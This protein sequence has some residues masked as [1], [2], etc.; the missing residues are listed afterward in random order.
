M[1]GQRSSLPPC[2]NVLKPTAT[3]TVHDQE[4]ASTCTAHAITACH[5]ILI[6]QRLRTRDIY[7][8]FLDDED[9]AKPSECISILARTGQ[10]AY[11]GTGKKRSRTEEESLSSERYILKCLPIERDIPSIK[12]KLCAGL[13]VV[14]GMHWHDSKNSKGNIVLADSSKRKTG[15]TKRRSLRN[16]KA[17]VEDSGKHCLLLIGY[18]DEEDA[19]GGG[20]FMCLNSHG[21]NWGTNGMGR[22]SYGAFMSYFIDGFAPIFPYPSHART[23]AG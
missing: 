13:P 5:E 11:A 17:Q 10:R 16:Q 4:D 22:M 12:A 20:W 15:D 7:P 2:C 14:L 18:L 9:G 3:I 19:E 1:P 6:G 8:S 21:N 23:M